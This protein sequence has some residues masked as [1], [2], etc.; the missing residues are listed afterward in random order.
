MIERGMTRG[1]AAVE[2][3]QQLSRSP[4]RTALTIRAAAT[5]ME[6]DQDHR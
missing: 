5:A 1:E 6:M 4:E 3:A 2:P